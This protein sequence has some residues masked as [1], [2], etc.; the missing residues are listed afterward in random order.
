MK[1]PTLM[2]FLGVLVTVLLGFGTIKSD[3]LT[4]KPATIKYFS[5]ER[6]QTNEMMNIIQ[7]YMKK[8]YFIH[9]S[10]T[11]GESSYVIVVFA[12]Y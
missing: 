6:A 3:I 8:G 7:S 12:K 2:F 5:V 10:M 1:N 9:S 11:S 4:I